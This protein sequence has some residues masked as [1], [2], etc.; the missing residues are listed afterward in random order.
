MFSKE[1]L[2]MLESG[3]SRSLIQGSGGPP[4]GGSVLTARCQITLAILTGILSS[5]RYGEHGDGA[6][7]AAAMTLA[8]ELVRQLGEEK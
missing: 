1:E 2:A 8:N 6:L 5:G 7:V 4:R 3:I